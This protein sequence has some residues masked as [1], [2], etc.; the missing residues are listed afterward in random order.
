MSGRELVGV[1]GGTFDPVH[2]GHL[3]I[4]SRVRASL[5]LPRLLL[6]PCALPPHKPPS[7][8]TPA[9]HREAMLRLA[10][11]DH[12]EL[13]TSTLEIDTG[14]VCYTIDT[15]RLMR[16]GGH[17]LEPVFILG[18]DA[19]IDLPTW[20]EFERLVR[21]FD[22]VV[23][24]RTDQP[25]EAARPRLHP[26]VAE[27]LAPV[28]DVERV[29]GALVDST[30]RG[31]IFSLQWDPIS[32]SSS[33]IRRRVAAGEEPDDLVPPAVAGYIRLNGLYRQEG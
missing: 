16:H 17:S 9:H 19:L 8:V 14:R 23:L 4:A 13:E 6:V 3:E 20:R 21:E 7:D 31:R 27:R 5:K 33:E 18:M 12:P 26:R 32:V 11:A 2:V 22:L 10:V 25:L 30:E 15:L 28:S 24:S 1:L 29:A